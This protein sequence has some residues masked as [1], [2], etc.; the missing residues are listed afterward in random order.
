MPHIGARLRGA[1]R[2]DPLD[3]ALREI[4]IAVDLVRSGRARVVELVGLPAAERAAGVGVAKAQAAGVR[5]SVLRS[6]S[7]A[8]TVSL[9][10]G[11]SF[12]DPSVDD[13]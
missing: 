5:F 11:R 12:D 1:R 2:P 4:D 6:G 10:I 3:V 8:R 7:G 13:G 9:R